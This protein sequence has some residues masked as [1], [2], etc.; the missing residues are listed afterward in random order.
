MPDFDANED[1]TLPGAGQGLLRT[2]VTNGAENRALGPRSIMQ[3]EAP[4]DVRVG[5]R[6][7]A[8]ER[9]FVVQI[10]HG[11][12]DRTLYLDEQGRERKYQDHH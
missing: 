8:I 6:I 12:R 4:E 11:G 9:I 1:V 3:A 10:N 7:P 5:V 2:H